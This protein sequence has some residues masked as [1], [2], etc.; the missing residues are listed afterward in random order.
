MICQG[1]HIGIY[2]REIRS[3]LGNGE[4]IPGFL[5]GVAHMSVIDLYHGIRAD[6]SGLPCKREEISALKDQQLGGR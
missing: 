5:E 2:S 3:Q 6:L 4:N 1:D